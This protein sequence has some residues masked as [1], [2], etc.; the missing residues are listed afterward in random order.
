MLIITL[1]E[2]FT[3]NH[4]IIS[5]FTTHILCYIILYIS[6]CHLLLNR[7]DSLR[8]LMVTTSV[9][10]V[11]QLCFPGSSEPLLGTPVHSKPNIKNSIRV[12]LSGVNEEFKNWRKLMG[13]LRQF[14]PSLKI[15][16]IKELPKGKY[17]LGTKKLMRF[18][19]GCYGSLVAV[20]MK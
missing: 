9:R 15:S 19:F 1:Q 18:Q 6:P 13:E 3:N 14:H 10:P 11:T 4:I 7:M 8:L 17:E 12:I 20:E 5:D 16:Q 2:Y